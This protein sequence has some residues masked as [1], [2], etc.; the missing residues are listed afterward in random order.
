M[1]KPRLLISFLLILFFSSVSHATTV[2]RLTLDDLVRKAHKIVVGKIVKSRSFWS[3]NAKLI[4]TAYTVEVEETIKGEPSHT[5]ELTTIGGTVG[6]R[7]LHVA[8][9]PSFAAGEN[10]ILF[11]ENSGVF[12]TVVGLEQGRFT[13]ANGEVSN[14]LTE[15]SFP[16]GRPGKPLKMP[17][18]NFKRQIKV[19][20]DR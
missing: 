14:A 5:I 12:S 6:D 15:L 17:L 13:V 20:L 11:V 1:R 10:A 19:I 8:G 3:G 2:Q 16:D 7:T 4:L 9:M 18:G